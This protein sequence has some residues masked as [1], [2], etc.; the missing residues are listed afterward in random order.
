MPSFSPVS[1]RRKFFSRQ[2][3]TIVG[4]L[5]LM[6]ALGA[7]IV[8][9][10][11]FDGFAPRATPET[12][13]KNIKVTNV[14]DTSF[15]VSFLTEASTI[16][17]VKYG[18]S[19]NELTSQAGDERDQLSG[20]VGEYTVHSIPVRGLSPSTTYHFVLGTGAQEEFDNQGA[21]LT[22][23]TA[24]PASTATIAKTIYGNVVNASGGPA[25]GSI[26][27]VRSEGSGELSALVKSSGSWA[28]PLNGA[29]TNDG[30]GLAEFT[31]DTLVLVIAQGSTP[32]LTAQTQ[33]SIAN[34]QPVET[35]T[36]GSVPATIASPLA[37]PSSQ[38]DIFESDTLP[39]ADDAALT[40]PT[41]TPTAQSP[42]ADNTGVNAVVDLTNPAPQ[43]VSTSQPV[44]VGQ[45]APNSLVTIEI[46]SDTQIMQQVTADS[47][48]LFTLDISEL[49]ETLEPG[50]HTVTYSY[51]NPTTRQNETKTQTFT[52]EAN[53]STLL[54][55]AN[56]TG[57][58]F[59]S[60][61][62]VSVA[63]VTPS[64]S[65][66]PSPSVSPSP[67]VRPASASASASNSATRSAV[68]SQPSTLSGM[69]ISGSTSTTIALIGGGIFFVL[70]GAWSF[71]VA[72]QLSANR[73]PE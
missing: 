43:T 54:A 65:P 58:P 1:G 24:S 32:E 55:Q 6:V 3:P 67:T 36:L 70:A 17:Y 41:A 40:L 25:E 72:Q 47:D 4:L 27:Y 12:T 50:E 53:T 30:S 44:I 45:A 13:P 66:S 39:D 33:V 10:K 15:T 64:P 18:T 68:T 23:T 71:W 34:A 11:G 52:V 31:D 22:V 48:G 9:F 8:L 61:N 38:S 21:P 42:L 37:S 29:R 57:G 49:S 19:P 28:I 62:P 20:S 14:T 59:G 7:G 73:D 60:G 69:P 16:G 51:Y 46:H 2:I 56:T 35:L 26:V 63:L 5:L